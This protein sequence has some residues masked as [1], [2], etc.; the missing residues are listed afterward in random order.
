MK[1]KW[2]PVLGAEGFYEVSS[3]GRVKSLHSRGRP[4]KTDFVT[5][6]KN[7]KGYCRACL[8]IKGKTR[9]RVVQRL[10]LEAFVGLAPSSLHECNHKDGVKSNNHVNNLEWVLPK[11]NNK[12]A[13]DMGLWHPHIGEKHGRAKLKEKDIPIIRSLEGKEAAI[14][15]ARRYGISDTA[16]RLIWKRRNWKHV[17]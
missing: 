9:T 1:E 15:I 13:R 10:V 7:K 8:S 12:H 14:L 3:F 6:T 16:V 4:T 17:K 5:L 2:K 11:A